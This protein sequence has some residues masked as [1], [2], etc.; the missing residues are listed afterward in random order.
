MTPRTCLSVLRCTPLCLANRSA[1][2]LSAEDRTV[3]RSRPGCLIP[4]TSQFTIR[5]LLY[6]AADIAQNRRGQPQFEPAIY[7]LLQTKK[8][9]SMS[10]CIHGW[11]PTRAPPEPQDF[12]LCLIIPSILN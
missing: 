8:T 3:P 2:M 5:H 1:Q 4:N 10:T 6:R 9:L 7:F 11:P 12:I